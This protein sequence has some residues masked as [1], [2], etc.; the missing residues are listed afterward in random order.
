MMQKI[1]ESE[2]EELNCIKQN[3]FAA[4]IQNAMFSTFGEQQLE[5]VDNNTPS[6]KLAMWKQDKKCRTH[7]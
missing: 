3:D 5:C 4:S 7:T 6:A 1:A 2:A